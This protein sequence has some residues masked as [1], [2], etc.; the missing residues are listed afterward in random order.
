MRA[1]LL[2]LIAAAS[3]VFIAYTQQ[4]DWATEKL[5]R[6]LA[7]EKNGL[8]EP[9][10]GITAKGSIEPGLF[11]IRST[12]VSTAPVRKAATAF[13]ASLNEDQ[14]KHTKFAIDDIEWRKW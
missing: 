7:A 4:K 9:Y 13:L 2:L 3:I 1:R 6:S 14:R 12:G 5:E 10:K 11:S 8:N